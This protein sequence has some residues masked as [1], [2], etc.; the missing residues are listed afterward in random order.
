[1]ETNLE[2]RP[3]DSGRLVN[4]KL[5]QR[6]KQRRTMPNET[7]RRCAGTG[8]FITMIVNGRPTGPGGICYRCRGKGI[9]T[10][11][12]QARNFWYDVRGRSYA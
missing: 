10:G 1:M 8:Q 6:A 11:D 3:G 7:C 12:D 5:G 2:I 4:W 9:L